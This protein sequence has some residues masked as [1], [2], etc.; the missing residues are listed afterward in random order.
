[1][2]SYAPFPNR[3]TV[4]RIR[5]QYPAG[6]R[7]ELIEMEDPYRKMVPGLQGT[8]IGVDDAGSL[9]VEWDNGST[10]SVIYGVDRVRKL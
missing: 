5:A 1:M 4:K 7:I 3:E 10:L 6:T 9:M 8:V 2:S